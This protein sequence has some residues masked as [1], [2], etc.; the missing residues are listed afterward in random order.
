MSLK[1]PQTDQK[2]EDP[3]DDLF[4]SLVRFL[5]NDRQGRAMPPITP[6]GSPPS[7]CVG[8]ELSPTPRKESKIDLTKFDPDPE[9]FRR[10]LKRGGE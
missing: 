1:E 10:S 9:E 5:Q 2:P 8:M 4:V 6:V 3:K 7:L